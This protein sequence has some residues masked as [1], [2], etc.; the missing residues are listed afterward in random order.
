[1]CSSH[2]FADPEMVIAHSYSLANVERKLQTSFPR[3]SFQRSR[4]TRTSVVTN[5]LT[6]PCSERRGSPRD[7]NA[8]TRVDPYRA[9]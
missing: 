1:M 4:P 7:M 5:Y 9:R 2:S 6:V 3:H 8:Q